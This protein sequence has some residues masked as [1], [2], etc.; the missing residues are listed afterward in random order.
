MVT[1]PAW[2]TEGL[3]EYVASSKVDKGRLVPGKI[4]RAPTTH[5]SMVQGEIRVAKGGEGVAA[6]LATIRE[7]A[8]RGRSLTLA[9]MLDAD[10]ETFH[11]EERRLYYGSAGLLV[12]FLRH[13]AP[14][15]EGE[16]F[17]TF[18]LYVAEGFPPSAALEVAYDTPVAALEESFR[19]YLAHL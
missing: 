19:S 3:A 10:R 18:L 2:L 15:W 1:L 8:R 11:G 12:H 16:P 7:A 9:Q 5:L 14:G 6:T 13:G 17:S 4:R